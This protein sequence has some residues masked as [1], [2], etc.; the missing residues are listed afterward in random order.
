[1]LFFTSLLSQT[2]QTGQSVSG[3][4]SRAGTTDPIGEADVTLN[5]APPSAA[6]LAALNSSS[7]QGI[8]QADL[9]AAL[10]QLVLLRPQEFQIALNQLKSQGQPEMVTLLTEWQAARDRSTGFPRRTTTDSSGRFS[11][12]DVPPGQYWL[13]TK[14]DGFFALATGGRPP[15]ETAWAPVSVATQPVS[16]ITISMVPGAL[17][18]GRVRDSAGRLQSNVNV[19]VFTVSYQTNQPILQPVAAK[20]TDDR[21]EYR[22]FWLRP[23][24][25]FVAATPRQG[26]AAPPIPQEAY[27]KSF[28]PN[29]ASITMAIPVSVKIGDERSGIDIEIQAVR[30]LK[31]SGQV[32]STLPAREPTGRGALA[33]SAATLMLLR[34]DTSI[35]DDAT[36]RMVGTVGLNGSTGTF[37]VTG[38]LPGAYDLY[39]RIMDP[40]G[41]AGPGGGGVFAWGR[42]SLDISNRDL[43]GVII[44]VH[45]SV[46]VNGVVTANGG[47]LSTA[48]ASARVVLQPAASTAKIPQYQGVINRAQTPKADGSFTIPAVAEGNYRVQILGLPP[49]AYI[50]DIQ[51]ESTSVYDSGISVTDKSP[52]PLQIRIAANGG[53]VEGTVYTTNKKVVPFATVTLI[54]GQDRRQN[55]DLFKTA[56]S[57]ALG[58]FVISGVRPDNYKLLAWDKVPPGASH[59]DG[60]IA[61]YEAQGSVI[62]VAAGT[63][64]AADV[65]L[66][67]EPT[68]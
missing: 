21:G 12:A 53:T 16:D 65:S 2:T 34:R 39:A 30:S 23:G 43:D 68:R 52:A 4:V 40:L 27:V 6:F 15:S 67:T 49:N 61:K 28:H 47:P 58:H 56:T 29:A 1:M 36:A 55:P 42:T 33:G 38:L 45:A 48:L 50:A 14:H 41:S 60:F 22:L 5:V 3:L 9:V 7:A 25:Y 11:V 54:P 24:E 66:L 57:D 8:S 37:E 13:V 59:N 51:Q 44:R 26:A 32:V 31:A 20:T 64:T 46:D 18:S 19:Q 10:I 17:I 35:P 63:K 62:K